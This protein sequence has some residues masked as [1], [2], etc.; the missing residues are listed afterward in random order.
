VVVHAHWPQ[1]LDLGVVSILFC[2]PAFE[3][4][5]AREGVLELFCSH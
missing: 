1:G 5:Q 4:S 3:A 2:D